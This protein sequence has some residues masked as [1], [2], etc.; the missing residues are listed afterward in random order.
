MPGLQQNIH[1]RSVLSHNSHLHVDSLRMSL[2]S[3]YFSANDNLKGFK[4]RLYSDSFSLFT[5]VEDFIDKVRL[6]VLLCEVLILLPAFIQWVSIGLDVVCSEQ[7]QHC[8]QAQV[9]HGVFIL[10]EILQLLES[11]RSIVSLFELD[12]MLQVAYE[13]VS[14]SVCRYL[15]FIR[16]VKVKIDPLPPVLLAILNFTL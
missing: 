13:D 11:C 3:Q 7:P 8:Y 1:S 6:A 14:D 2:A 4:E 9:E 12:Y 15:S 10:Y 5:H 16:H